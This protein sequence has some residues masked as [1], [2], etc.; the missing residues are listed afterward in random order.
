MA[1]SCTKQTS[2]SLCAQHECVA[3]VVPHRSPKASLGTYGPNWSLHPSLHLSLGGCT[4]LLRGEVPTVLTL[5]SQQ[6]G[7]M[8]N[9]G[10][11][12]A[13]VDG[14]IRAEE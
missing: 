3:K 5:P 6:L 4:V 1:P 9:P 11:K 10:S 7:S 12:D 8:G 2:S 14:S 13:S